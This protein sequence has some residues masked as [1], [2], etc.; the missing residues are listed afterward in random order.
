MYIYIYISLS[1]SLSVCVCEC[2]YIYIYTYIY[3]YICSFQKKVSF[4]GLPAVLL[5]AHHDG[6][7]GLEFLFT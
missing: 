5:L 3:I 4:G 6:V 1:L 2:M 7:E